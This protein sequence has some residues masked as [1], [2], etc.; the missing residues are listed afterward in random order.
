MSEINDI[1]RMLNHPVMRLVQL[2][3]ICYAAYK[4]VSK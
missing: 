1:D 4:L 2:V 3:L